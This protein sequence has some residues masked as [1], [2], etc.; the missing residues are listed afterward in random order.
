MSSR[1]RSSAV[2]GSAG[3]DAAVLLLQIRQRT[4]PRT[5]TSRSD[6]KIRKDDNDKGSWSR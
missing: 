5:G 4:H 2:G 1:A 3:T 6:V